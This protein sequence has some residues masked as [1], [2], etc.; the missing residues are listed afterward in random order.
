[1]PA[2]DQLRSRAVYMVGVFCILAQLVNM[3]LMTYAYGGWTT[4]HLIS[5]GVVGILI[6]TTNLLRWSKKYTH[7]AV[8]YSALTLLAVAGT[9]IPDG[10]GI[11]SSMLPILVSGVFIA[12][13]IAG[14]RV[15]LAYAI[16]AAALIWGLYFYSASLPPAVGVPVE[17]YH[18]RIFIRATQAT[19]ALGISSAALGVFSYSMHKLFNS[20]KKNIELAKRAELAKS[21]FLANMSH[22]LRTP[23]NGVIGMTGLLQKTELTPTQRH[24]VDIVNGCSTGLVAIIND[25]LDLSKLESGKSQF[26]FKTFDLEAMLDSLI[27]LHRPAAIEKGLNLAL[28]WPNDMPS[29]VISDES[30]LRQIANNL[31]GNAVK[32][33]E[34]GRVDVLVQHRAMNR[35]DGWMEMCLFVRDTGVG[36]PAESVDLV[37]NRFEQVDNRLSATT[38]GTGLGLAITQ[39]LVEKMGGRIHVE[40]Q[41]GEGTTFTVQLPLRQDRRALSVDVPVDVDAGAPAV[42][43]ASVPVPL[44]VAG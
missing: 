23:L 5:C 4:D 35:D 14:W 44:K 17:G 30:R 3:G 25:V 38:P 41:F 42:E 11:N 10:T 2:E 43:E 32:F 20:L 19:L 37:F 9:S 26:S 21:N 8:F 16:S 6:V 15:M 28:Y 39:N 27:S 33:T 31:I 18:A 22:E 29:R 7:Y 12:V 24:Y 13:F 34:R 1:M 36:I 40:S